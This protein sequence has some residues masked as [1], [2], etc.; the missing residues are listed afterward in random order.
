MGRYAVDLIAA[1]EYCAVLQVRVPPGG[2]LTDAVVCL[3]G[4]RAA[5]VEVREWARSR[6]L[7]LVECGPE[8]DGWRVEHDGP[9]LVYQLCARRVWLPDP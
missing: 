9:E 7:R 6:L 2:T 3:D 4:D 1:G 8:P 5:E